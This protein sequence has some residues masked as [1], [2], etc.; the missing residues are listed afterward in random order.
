MENTT[1]EV[2]TTNIGFVG[3]VLL[4]IPVM[5]EIKEK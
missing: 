3:L 4:D 2:L 5:E 1:M